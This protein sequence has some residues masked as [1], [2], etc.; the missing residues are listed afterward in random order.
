MR[1]IETAA[2]LIKDNIK[3]MKTSHCNYPSFDELKPEE[4]IL[5]L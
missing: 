5:C 2:K 3:A 4:C 1:I